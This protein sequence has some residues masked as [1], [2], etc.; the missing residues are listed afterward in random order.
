MA[1][2]LE[3]GPS[4]E[5]PG[6]AEDREADASHGFLAPAVGAHCED[7]RATRRID[8]AT[9]EQGPSI[10]YMERPCGILPGMEASAGP[11][12]CQWCI[13]RIL[14][15]TASAPSVPAIHTRAQMR[16]GMAVRSRRIRASSA[17]APC[18]KAMRTPDRRSNHVIA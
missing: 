14:P 8:A 5:T 16:R 15:P 2:P 18:S 12:R 10:S 6:R 11:T 1:L 3:T 17:R 13:I 9:P 7:C 4:G